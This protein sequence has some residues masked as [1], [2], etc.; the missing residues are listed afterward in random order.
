M[1]EH[2]TQFHI[3]LAVKR[4]GGKTGGVDSGSRCAT[5]AGINT[6]GT[7][8]VYRTCADAL[9]SNPGLSNGIYNLDFDDDNM[10]PPIFAYCDM[11]NGG[12]MRLINNNLTS[13]DD[14]SIFS[15][16][17]SS[18]LNGTYVDKNGQT[19][20]LFYTDHDEMY[21][22]Y[23]YASISPA[24]LPMDSTMNAIGW[25]NSANA[26]FAGNANVGAMACVN[27]DKIP[28]YSK[29]KFDIGSF[30]NSSQEPG[31]AGDGTKYY[32][33]DPSRVRS[34]NY[35]RIGNEDMDLDAA[36]GAD[37]IRG[38]FLFFREPWNL[39][40]NGSGGYLYGVGSMYTYR[41]PANPLVRT[42]NEPERF[43]IFKDYYAT[44][45]HLY[46]ANDSYFC[47]YDSSVAGVVF[48]T[49]K[50]I[51]N[52]GA[53]YCPTGIC[54]VDNQWVEKKSDDSCPVAGVDTLKPVNMYRQFQCKTASNE[55]LT[56]NPDGTCP[57]GADQGTREVTNMSAFYP[58]SNFEQNDTYQSYM[59]RNV[60]IDRSGTRLKICMAGENYYYSRV[61]LSNLYIQ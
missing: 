1:M 30:V 27:F 43:Y 48:R 3:V 15:S 38:Q 25:G 19:I 59:F 54:Y 34:Y 12:W 2:H 26:G 13:I 56:V 22:N 8:A 50:N 52:A 9:A 20:P 41:N 28:P 7:C 46:A 61:F 49:A 36:S 60:K 14:L 21:Q 57:A 5:P 33:M 42:I 18:T 6:P 51:D 4:L 11:A 47:Q 53:A 45:S 16:T 35:A 32:S 39:F 55:W 44:D 10:T 29:V 31:I 17:A 24:I 58:G 40:L 37:D 23:S